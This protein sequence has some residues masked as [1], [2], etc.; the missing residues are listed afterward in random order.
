MRLGFDAPGGTFTV[1][2]EKS[3]TFPV[4]RPPE[5]Q[6]TGATVGAVDLTGA[7]INVNLSL[8]NP[9]SYQLPSSS[10]DYAISLDGRQLTT[11][12][13]APG[14]LPAGAESPVNLALHV[15]FLRAGFAVA[16]ALQS[17]NAELSLDG[18]LD[19]AGRKIPLHLRQPLSR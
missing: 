15:D 13:A 14:P 19:L 10:L 8:R 5:V 11:G 18:T 12:T 2:I 6:L 1:P 9:N 17:S 16:N 3:G 7:S 4:P